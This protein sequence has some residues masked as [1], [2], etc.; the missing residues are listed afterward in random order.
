MV[1]ASAFATARFAVRPARLEDA[2]AIAEVQV[3]SWRSSYRGILPDAILDS[4]NAQLRVH[5]RQ[6][7]LRDP[8]A[9]NLV[10]YDTTHGDVVGYA[11]ASVSRRGGARVGEL[12]E[13]YLVDRAK[14]YGLGRELFESVMDWSRAKQHA[15]LDVWVLEGNQHARRFYAAMG[16]VVS[17]QTH[18]R[19][20]GFGVIELAYSFKL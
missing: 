1:I 17:A 14:R 7:M 5:A 8:D 6:G 3:A 19:V 4:L 2:A 18:S 15:R 9:Y 20:R 10:A 16:G 12:F 13:I 11:N